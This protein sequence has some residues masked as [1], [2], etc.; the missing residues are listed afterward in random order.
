MGMAYLFGVAIMH[1]G[2]AVH[3]CAQASLINT[4]I[5]AQPFWVLLIGH[6]SAC[7]GHVPTSL[8]RGNGG[9]VLRLVYRPEAIC[10]VEG[11]LRVERHLRVHI[12]ACVDKTDGVEVEL[13]GGASDASIGYAIILLLEVG[14]VDGSIMP[15]IGL[16][17]YAEAIALRLVLGKTAGEVSV[18]D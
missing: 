18:S 15:G 10:I 2:E 3:E 16:P 12:D 7:C 6:C 5:G 8:G 4:Q 11:E 1:R 9:F 17:P 13:D 14:G